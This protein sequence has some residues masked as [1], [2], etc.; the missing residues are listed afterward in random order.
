LPDRP[1]G[2][3]EVHSIW[4][5]SDQTLPAAGPFLNRVILCPEQNR[6]Y[7]V[8]AWLFAPGRRKYEYMIQFQALLD[9]FECGAAR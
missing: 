9:S 4:R 6:T 3:F 1:E 2:S 5:S 8:E 7:F